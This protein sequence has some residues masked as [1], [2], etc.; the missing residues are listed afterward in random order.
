MEN[1]KPKKP[2]DKT[3]Y[4]NFFGLDKKKWNHQILNT[5]KRKLS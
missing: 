3:K 1:P 5:L 2:W 4:T